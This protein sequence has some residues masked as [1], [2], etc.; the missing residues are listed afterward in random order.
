MSDV[1]LINGRVLTPGGWRDDLAVHVEGE[2]IASLTRPI[3]ARPRG[4]DIHDLKGRY[5]LPGFIDCQVNGGGDVLF[6]DQPSLDGIRAIAAA[7]RR[8]GTTGLLPTLISDSAE[9]MST[10]VSAVDAAIAARTPGV[11]GIHIEGPY[12]ALA[13]KGVHDAEALRAPSSRELDAITA[14]QR[15]T[16]LLTLAPERVEP[17]ALRAL[18][19][20]GVIVAAGH[21]AANYA[22]IRGALD[23]GV[24]G[25]THLFNAMTQL[26]S[27]EP[28]A[29]GAA[30]ED[31]A[32][33][34]GVIV[35][36]RHVHPATLHVAL[37]A[38]PR[39]KVFLV[40]DAMP[41]VG[42]SQQTFTLH[43][44]TISVRNGA[45]ETAAGV[46]AGS[47]LSLR[48]AVQNCVQLLGLPL[49]EAVRMA[50]TNPADFLGLEKSHGRIAAGCQADFTVMDE[51]FTV[52]ETWIGGRREPAA[53][54]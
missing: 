45:C 41:P 25:F 13:R 9:V 40:S 2:R 48:D 30:L 44:E 21:T 35:D 54:R 37:A 33:W 32:S 3:D 50:S 16:T 46:L 22:A 53:G 1:V 20:A 24:R 18:I 36:G 8:L 28:G 4:A 43:G 15:G 51:A 26:G 39:G 7:H 19:K 31:R 10:A 29:V 17:D 12:L 14:L 34:C 47:V 52:H 11:L 27:R 38:K 5:L 6:N 23:Q 42:G 49:D